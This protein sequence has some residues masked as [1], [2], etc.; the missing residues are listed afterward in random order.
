VVLTPLLI[1]LGTISAFGEQKQEAPSQQK[2]QVPSKSTANLYSVDPSSISIRTWQHTPSVT[3]KEITVKNR[4]YRVFRDRATGHELFRLEIGFMDGD[5]R[6]NMWN[7][8]ITNEGDFNGDGKLDYAWYAGDDTSSEMFILLSGP[9]G[10]RKL[11]VYPTVVAE[12]NRKFPYW[13]GALKD[14]ETTGDDYDVSSVRFV[15]DAEGLW[16]VA[17]V[18]NYVGAKRYKLRIP[19][20]HFKFAE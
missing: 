16:L 1:A 2:L 7:Y 5:Q 3:S 8:G 19:E 20:A 12:W 4:F 17:T 10:F 9:A 14:I 13:K 15:R 11:D 18:L 6:V